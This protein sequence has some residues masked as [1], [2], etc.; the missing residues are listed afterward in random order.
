MQDGLSSSASVVFVPSCASRED[1]PVIKPPLLSVLTKFRGDLQ[2]KAAGNQSPL[3]D[4]EKASG[5]ASGS[6]GD[7]D[8]QSIDKLSDGLDIDTPIPP[9][10]KTLLEVF[11]K[12]DFGGSWRELLRSWLKFEWSGGDWKNEVSPPSLL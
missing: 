8:P 10:I 5:S 12:S 1:A 3:T 6:T 9:W 7:G 11:M 4:Q 2:T